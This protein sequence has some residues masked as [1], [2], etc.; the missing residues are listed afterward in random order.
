[1]IECNGAQLI[2]VDIFKV[3]C[4]IG[5]K[6]C[7][8]FAAMNMEILTFAN[9]SCFPHH[10]NCKLVFLNHLTLTLKSKIRMRQN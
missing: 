3:R 1:M 7:K 10:N 6:R 5:R 8:F 2:G 4:Q 9:F